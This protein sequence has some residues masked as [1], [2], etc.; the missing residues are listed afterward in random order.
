MNPDHKDDLHKQIDEWL[1]QG[2]IEPSVSL[3]ALPLG[4][5]KK[6]DGRTR[7]VTDLREL[8]KQTLKDN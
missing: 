3:W 6:K 4:P 2:V 8:N 1:Q 7:W 5:V